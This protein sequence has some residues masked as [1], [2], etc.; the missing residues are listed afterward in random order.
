VNER[1]R[2]VKVARNP[3]DGS[4]EIFADGDVHRSVLRP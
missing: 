2:H 3:I 1:R 4:I